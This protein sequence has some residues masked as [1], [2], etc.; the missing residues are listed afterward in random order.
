MRRLGGLAALLMVAA[1]CSGSPASARTSPAPTDGS[2]SVSVA[3][4]G[5]SVSPRPAGLLFAVLEAR[6]P[7]DGPLTNDTVAIAGL[8]GYARAKTTFTPRRVP[9]L[10]DAGMLTQPEARV[11][12]G[13]VFFADGTGKIRSLDPTGATGDVTTFNLQAQ[14]VLSFAVDPSGSQLLGAVLTVPT[15][16]SPMPCQQQGQF[17]V[18]LYTAQAGGSA[19]GVY[20]QTYATNNSDSNFIQ[21]VGWDQAGAAITVH[22]SIGTQNGTLGQKWFGQ[23]AHYSQP[24]G[25]GSVVGGA[26]CRA[27]DERGSSIAC[28]SSSGEG[29]GSVRSPDGSIQ[30]NLPSGIYYFILLSPDGSH[31]AYCNSSGCGVAG[32]DGGSARLPS[33]FGPRGWLDGSTLIG[34][35]SSQPVPPDYGELETLSLSD[36][37]NVNDLGFTGMFV[38]AVQTG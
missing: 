14:Q 3:S 21:A 18:D 4:P 31:A 37:A 19:A 30:W 36:M 38:G 15:Y 27:Q 11:A 13:K 5:P 17:A 16:T 22:T 2:P 29:A 1:A 33:G 23:L 20:H 35:R 6:R 34:T 28:I 8:D 25:V 10:C 9:E 32:R 24:G 26:D 7:G 12:D